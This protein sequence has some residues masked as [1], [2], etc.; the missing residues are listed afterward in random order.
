[1]SSQLQLKSVGQLISS[2]VGIFHSFKDVALIINHI[3][4]DVLIPRSIGTVQI[5]LND[6]FLLKMI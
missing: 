5:G 3:P 6:L 1:M 2:G 4:V